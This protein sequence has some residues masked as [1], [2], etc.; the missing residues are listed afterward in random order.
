MTNEELE[1]AINFIIEQHR[2]ASELIAALARNQGEHNQRLASLEEAQGTMIEANA[3][4][5]QLSRSLVESNRSTRESNAALKE[6]NE[7][8]LRFVRNMDERLDRS[9]ERT[10]ALEEAFQMIADIAARQD[11]AYARSKA[12][13]DAAVAPRLRRT[14]KHHGT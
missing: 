9:N 5:V 14:L 8:L 12:E 3:S 13:G 2:S 1:G 4:L 10:A 6:S 11:G 7:L